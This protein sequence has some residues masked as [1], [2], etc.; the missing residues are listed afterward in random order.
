[1][2]EFEMNLLKKIDAGEIL[3]EE[4]IRTFIYECE[5]EAEETGENRRWSRSVRTIMKLDNRF[6]AVEWEKGL[7]E[8]QENCFN[9]QPYEVTKLTINHMR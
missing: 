8:N 9:N 1:M 5:Q 4:E 2:G 7:T 3:S 6:F